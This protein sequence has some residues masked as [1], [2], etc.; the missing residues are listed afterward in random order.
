MATPQ[1]VKEGWFHTPGRPGDRRLDQQLTGLYPA[2]AYCVNKS[3]LDVGCAEGLISHSL[4]ER[5]AAAVHGLE[6]VPGHVEVANKFRGDLPC[7]FE[8]ADVNDYVPV[9]RYDIVLLLG[10]LHKLRDPSAV[11]RRFAAAARSMV[12]I[13]LP[14]VRAPFIVDPRSDNRPHDIEAVMDDAGF[15]RMSVGCG[16]FNEWVGTY[17]R[18]VL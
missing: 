14:P 7:T 16:H 2:L 13:R 10:I 8:V 9:R 6:I 11:C 17:R 12:V 3:I 18:K 1:P 15:K 5:G 4:A